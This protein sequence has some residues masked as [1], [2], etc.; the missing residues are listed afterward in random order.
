[1]CVVVI[2]W[3]VSLLRL[4]QNK[5]PPK[6]PKDVKDIGYVLNYDFPGSI[7]TYV[8]RVGRT[9]RAGA[10]GVAISYFTP[11]NFKSGACGGGRDP[12]ASVFRALRR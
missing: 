2:V 3:T 9:G 10:S 12:C 8:H 1:M 7:E 11:E 4:C 5:K 6:K